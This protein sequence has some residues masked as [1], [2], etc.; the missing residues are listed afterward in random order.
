[1]KYFKDSTSKFNW[2]NA[3]YSF[4]KREVLDGYTESPIGHHRLASDEMKESEYFMQYVHRYKLHKIALRTPVGYRITY[5]L[6]EDI[7]N[8]SLGINAPT[9]NLTNEINGKLVN[10]LKSRNWFTAV[11]KMTA[12]TLEQG[13]AILLLYTDDVESQRD[14]DSWESEVDENAE[15]LQ[16]E[17]VNRINYRILEW[18]ENGEPLY[19]DVMIKGGSGGVHGPGVRSLR[20]HASRVL[21][22]SDKDIY[23]RGYGFARLNISYDSI[24]I[25]SNI[26]KG[27][28]E[29]AYR[30][31]TGHPLILT[32]DVTDDT[33]LNKLKNA[34]GT[35]TR[36]SW[37]ILPSEY[38]DRFDL[39]GQAGQ[40]L[41]FK[42]LAD[43]V[44]DQ[45]I[46][47][48]K[49]PRPILLG[50]VAGVVQGSEINERSYFA[51]LDEFHTNLEPFVR[52]CFERDVNIKKLLSPLKGKWELDW[53]IREVLNRID[54]A[55][56]DQMHISNTLALT[57]II[58]VNEAR[59]RM[60]MEPLPDLRGEIVLGVGP[61]PGSI[62]EENTN[63]TDEN[64]T[65]KETTKTTEKQ[66]KN[67]KDLEKDK[68]IKN[69]QNKLRENKSKI[70][71]SLK[72]L[73]DSHSVNEICDLFHITKKTFYKI[74]K[75]AEEN[76]I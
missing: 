16:Y 30:W 18:T 55:K 14:F 43:I 50:E 62:P 32:K 61:P 42:A 13:E 5:G 39:I 8:N 51:V 1:M 74:L 64:N 19:Y 15:I 47:A 52:R 25:L 2:D 22:F 7:W 60:G 6:A 63:P 40:M 66:E 57:S 71:D 69:P 28:G 31:G 4:G 21:R 44:I 75:Q 29:A 53:G 12:F 46:I 45:I 41:N 26:I 9:V 34:I 3:S 20:V 23:Q 48:S 17:A 35:P 24:V 10:Y 49:I 72:R 37:H 54:Q 27:T 38:I 59:A 11:E 73:R 68:N 76:E 33:Q 67:P 65:A 58:T 56:L 36:R 70:A